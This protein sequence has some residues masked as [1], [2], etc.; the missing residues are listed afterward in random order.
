MLVLD[1]VA[2][3]DRLGLADGEIVE[4]AARIELDLVADDRDRALAGRRGGRDHG[5][6]R[7]VVDI[8]VIGEHVDR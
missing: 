5:Q 6:H 2:D 7:A 4:I 3:H 1:R 8:V